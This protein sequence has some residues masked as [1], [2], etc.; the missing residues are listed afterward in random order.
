MIMID[1]TFLFYYLKMNE[2]NV[3]LILTVNLPYMFT[4]DI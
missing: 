2:L 4:V 3:K 1:V